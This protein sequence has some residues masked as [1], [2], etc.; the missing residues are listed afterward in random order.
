MDKNIVNKIIKFLK[1]NYDK[2]DSLLKFNSV[3]ELTIMVLLGARSTDKQVNIATKRLFSEY[4]SPESMLKLT[5]LQLE[6]FIRDV[7][8]FRIKAANILNLCAIIV[9]KYKGNIPDT[10]ES[11]I[12]L[13]GIGLKSANVIL[14]VGF[15][16]PAFAVDTHVFRVAKRLGF[17]DG[18]TVKQVEKD[19]K[20]IICKKY[21]SNVHH[22]LVYHGRIIC[23]SRRPKCKWYSE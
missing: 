6:N 16:K 2:T 19:S 7:G 11:L 22:W 20:N 10:Y 3:F 15:G 8:L 13:P 12:E 9:K 5:Q 4:D 21:W 1:T 14:S 18:K 23:I 17:S